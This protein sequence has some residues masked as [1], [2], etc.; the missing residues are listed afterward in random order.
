MNLK[1]ECRRT[2]FVPVLLQFKVRVRAVLK[3]EALTV[4]HP[5][6]IWT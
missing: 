6:E 3:L 1:S 2:A 5:G 4:E